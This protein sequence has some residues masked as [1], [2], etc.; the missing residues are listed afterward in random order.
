MTDR[1][2][3]V[4]LIRH[5]TVQRTPNGWWSAWFVN[6]DEQGRRMHLANYR[7]MRAAKVAIEAAVRRMDAEGRRYA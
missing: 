6:G 4:L 1:D 2:R 5:M 7:T 3:R